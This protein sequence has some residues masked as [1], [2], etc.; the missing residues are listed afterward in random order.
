MRKFTNQFMAIFIGLFLLLS[1]G[2][3]FY[4]TQVVYRV[5]SDTMTKDVERHAFYISKIMEMEALGDAN[6]VQSA[7]NNLDAVQ[8]LLEEDDDIALINNEGKLI[9]SS[10]AYQSSVENQA[11]TREVRRV[12]EGAA[13]GNSSIVKNPADIS[14]FRVAVPLFNNQR[15]QIGILRLTHEMQ[16]LD[17][18]QD[19]LTRS[20]FV[21]SFIASVMAGII[22]YYLSKRI[23]KPLKG[24]TNTIESISEGDYSNH[25][26]GID[27]PEVAELGNTVN[28]LAENLESKNREIIQ[29]NE[30][31]SVLVDRLI[32]GVVLLDHQ[33]QIQLMNRAAQNILD[34]DEKLLGRSFLEMT[35]SYGLVQIIQQ[36]FQENKSKNEEIY[37]YHPQERILDVNTMIVPNIM[38]R[39]VI[40][41]LYDITQIRR[42]EKVRTDF[43]ANASHELRT[44][45]TALKG[46]AEVL[47]D[48]AMEDPVTCK[49]FLEIIYK[50]SKRLE[51]L[52]NDILELSRVEQKQVPLNREI[53]NLSE[54][55][56][57]CFQVIRP[58][59]ASKDIN[60]R[61]YSANPDD[62]L[63]ETDRG[64]LEQVLNNLI[65]NAVNYT[66]AGGKISI[67]VEKVGNE[68]AIHIADTGIGIPEE[69]LSRIFERFYRVDK[70]RSRNSGGTG[71]G[72]SI[73]RYLVQNLNGRI[74]VKSKLGIGTTFSVYLPLL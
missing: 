27:Y 50:E 59:A 14:E 11:N 1:M 49:Q 54:I 40:V 24:I 71:L 70:A 66:D 29:S 68:A 28:Q 10:N 73:V 43:V 55:I 69:D 5:T 23:S 58:Q 38:G 62:I 46:F 36:T 19:S 67:M 35:K 48:G 51:I 12:M 21:F 57:S 56:K 64:R 13:S 72:L 52:V 53:L 65:T 63:L 6:N 47:L 26:I 60:L 18:L 34:V 39:Q 32:V 41:L 2:V 15:Q 4:T 31:L 3:V 17:D 8:F 16:D 42:L 30:K 22:A 25:Y 37:I 7:V 33:Q 74:E 9:Y 61:F 44:P 20:V 45:V